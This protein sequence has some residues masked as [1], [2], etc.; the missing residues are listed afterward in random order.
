MLTGTSIKSIWETVKKNMSGKPGDQEFQ[1]T[2][3]SLLKMSTNSK[4][5]WSISEENK[6][7]ISNFKPLS[8][9]E[10][11]D[12]EKC[13]NCK[14]DLHSDQDTISC[15]ECKVPLHIEC[16]TKCLECARIGHPECMFK[17]LK[18]GTLLHKECAKKHK[19]LLQQT[20]LDKIDYPVLETG[21][22]FGSE[23]YAVFLNPGIVLSN[24][25]TI[26]DDAIKYLGHK[27]QLTEKKKVLI[28]RPLK[29]DITL[30]GKKKKYTIN[31]MYDTIILEKNNH[32]L[33]S[34]N[35][36]HVTEHQKQTLCIKDSDV[37]DNPYYY[38]IEHDI[39]VLGIS[40]ISSKLRI[41]GT[42]VHKNLHP[43]KEL[44]LIKKIREKYPNRFE[45]KIIDMYP[46]SDIKER[47]KR[48][49]EK[50]KMKTGEIKVTNCFTKK[51]RLETDRIDLGD[52]SKSLSSVD[53][54]DIPVINQD[55]S[56]II[57]DENTNLS[58]Y[59]QF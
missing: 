11:F 25:S 10:T 38:S 36:D 55:N 13:F 27:H 57:L 41:I 40:N 58:L 20:N 52:F 56:N 49:N 4:F 22:I 35:V 50:F 43:E 12:K 31:D 34:P 33:L 1:S 45:N 19:D 42:P 16:S 17:C 26:F 54:S 29:C 39:D 48:S 9:V 14:I 23:Q 5:G 24:P 18:C 30:N 44:L 32:V 21:R 2:R 37:K 53:D 51:I 59:D 3:D 46:E 8:P 15:E 7:A 47:E 28:F 6:I